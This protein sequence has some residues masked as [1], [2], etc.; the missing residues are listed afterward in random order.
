VRNDDDEVTKVLDFGIAKA[1]VAAGSLGAAA[2]S[3]TRTGAVLGTPYYMSPE[4][5]E[6]ARSLDH[7]TDIWAMGVI[8]FE[9][10]LGRRPFDA[11]TLGGLLLAICTRPIPIPS[12]CGP[13]PSGFDAWFARACN[14]DLAQRFSSARDA[15][16]EL[17]RVCD[18]N[19]SVRGSSSGEAAGAA[20]AP[21]ASGPVSALSGPLVGSTFS[22]PGQSVAGLSAT[23]LDAAGVPKRTSNRALFVLLCGVGLTIGGALLA[24]SHFNSAAVPATSAASRPD[25]ARSAESTPQPA[26]STP[27]P[28]STLIPAP[29]PAESVPVQPA[30]SASGRVQTAAGARTPSKRP[31]PTAATSPARAAPSSPPAKPPARP[32]VNLGI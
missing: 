2:S 27:T 29:P 3:A 17:K 8:A 10:L 11:E 5:I 14:R 7:R 31:P 19:T 4:Q 13:V 21:G 24:W 22:V 25:S 20:S 12:Q 16:L 23:Q 32:A 30:A 15:A 9:C 26:T 28:A 18:G 6:G 1:T